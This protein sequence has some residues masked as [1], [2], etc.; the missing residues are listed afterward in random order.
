MKRMTQLFCKNVP[1][2]LVQMENA[3]ENKDIK[4]VASLAHKMKPSVEDLNITSILPIINQLNVLSG[5]E[6]NY[7]HQTSLP[8]F[9]NHLAIALYPLRQKDC[10][11]RYVAKFLQLLPNYPYQ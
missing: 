9:Q 11:P 5:E 8:I 4:T 1:N 2:M 6:T 3:I 10:P 7:E